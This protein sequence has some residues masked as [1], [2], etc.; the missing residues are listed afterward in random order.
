MTEYLIVG[1]GVAGTTAAESIRKKDKEGKITIVTDENIPFYYRLR[2][3]EYIS[4]DTSEQDLIGRKKE[5]Y[6]DKCIDLKLKTHVFRIEP[7]EKIVVMDGSVELPYDRI[8]IAAGSHSF[9]PPIKG[10]D[11]KGVFALRTIKDARDIC[12]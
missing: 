6:K 12:A 10:A 4:R 5:W 11:K 2:L 7:K 3:N 1:N 8:L 9:I